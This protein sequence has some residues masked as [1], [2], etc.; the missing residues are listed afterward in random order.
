MSQR[1]SRAAA[2]N[3]ID[4]T[5]SPPAATYSLHARAHA[6]QGPAEM[7]H[8][9]ALRISSLAGKQTQTLPTSSRSHVRSSSSSKQQQT[10][11]N[12][13]KSG[14]A[15]GSLP[16]GS[17]FRGSSSWS[18]TEG[19]PGG[20]EVREDFWGLGRGHSPRSPVWSSSA[21][22]LDSRLRRCRPLLVGEGY[23]RGSEH[24][25]VLFSLGAKVDR[26]VGDGLGCRGQQKNPTRS[27]QS[28]MSLSYGRVPS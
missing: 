26:S 22:H 17:S 2:A 20:G 18:R 15:W 28:L 27:E 25:G 10:D 8:A 23:D 21:R 1:G 16:P 3:E 9:T 13:E 5:P 6:T 14:A 11:K 12:R 4:R 19:N 24:E 7:Q